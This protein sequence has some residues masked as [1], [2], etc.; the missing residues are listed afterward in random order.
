MQSRIPE[1][2]TELPTQSPFFKHVGPFY[3]RKDGDVFLMRMPTGVKHER[4]GGFVAGGVL[5]TLA[6]I[7]QGTALAF[8]LWPNPEDLRANQMRLVTVSLNTEYIAPGPV[9]T[10]LQAEVTVT[11]LGN[12]ICY[13]RADI[14]HGKQLVLTS[15]AIFSVKPQ[16]HDKE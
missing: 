1:G 12:T 14:K 9:G 10:W 3:F 16:S 5:C 4:G 2:Y 15:T 6:D 8:K 11:K 7:A 13:T